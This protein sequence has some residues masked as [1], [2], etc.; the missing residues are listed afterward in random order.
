MV[1]RFSLDNLPAGM[2]VAGASLSLYCVLDEF[3]LFANSGLMAAMTRRW[4]DRTATWT[5]ADSI[6][7]W[8]TPG[9]DFD[10][11]TLMYT[12]RS[13]NDLSSTWE[14]FDVTGFVSAGHSDST[15]NNGFLLAVFSG[16]GH[17]YASSEYPVMGLRPKL[18]VVLDS[19]TGVEK[20]R[21]PSRAPGIISIDSRRAVV[22][23]DRPGAFSLR[24]IDINGKIVFHY[25]GYVSA[26]GQKDI[27][28]TGLYQGTAARVSV[29]VLESRGQSVARLLAHLH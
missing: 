21:A 28:L 8:T 24:I 26:A 13:G 12:S 3:P 25:Q 7:P 27:G 11:A 20:S 4:D 1:I 19:A 17:Q 14:T 6:T 22:F 29:A 9:G 15:K 10:N 5:M 23:L 16:D 2:T 18:T